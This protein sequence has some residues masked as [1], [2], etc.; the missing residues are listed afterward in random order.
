MSDAFPVVGIGASAGGLDACK[1]VIA[2][3]PADSG[4]ALILVQ[5]LDPSQDSTLIEFLA[6]HTTMCV[7][8]ASDGIPIKRDHLYV[9]PPGMYLSVRDGVLHLNHPRSSHGPQQPV[10]FLLRS[11]AEDLDGRA[12]CVI[13]SGAGT[14][15]SIGCK[16]IREK[17]GLTIA[18]DPDEAGPAG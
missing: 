7:V 2:A 1:K 18:Q 3:L 14:D 4:I 8:Q 9:I 10:D 16:A 12:A 5:H 13:L 15:G 17:G 11:L 6:D